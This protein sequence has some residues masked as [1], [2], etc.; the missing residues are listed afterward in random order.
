MYDTKFERKIMGLAAGQA[1]LLTITGRKSDCEFESMRLSHQKIALA[2]Q[3]ADLSN[4]YQN[5]MEQT[6]LVYDY[7]GTGDTTTPLSYSL[8]MTPSALNNYTPITLTDSMGRVVLNSMLA[9]AA[10]AAG[11]PQEGLGTLP[12]ETMRNK[13]IIALGENGTITPAKAEKISSLPYSQQAGFGG[14]ATVSVNTQELSFDQLVKEL[15]NYST[16]PTNSKYANSKYTRSITLYDDNNENYYYNQI[17]TSTG[18][19][20]Q[21]KD[22]YKE[23][24]TASV[25][26]GDILNGNF[27]LVATGVDNWNCALGYSGG[28]IDAIVN[29]D[30]WEQ[31]YN[32]IDELFNTGDSYT[33]MALDYAY[34][35]ISYLISN[36]CENHGEGSGKESEAGEASQYYNDTDLVNFAGKYRTGKNTSDYRVINEAR[37]AVSNNRT[38]GEKYIGLYLRFSKG[39]GRDDDSNVSAVSVN[40]SNVFRAYLTYIVDFMEGVSKTDIK[41]EELYK[42][43]NSVEESKLVDGNTKFTIKIGSEVSSDDMGLAVFYDTLF[44][45]ICSNG[46]VENDKITDNDYLKDML[47]N[48]IYYVS[49]MKDD[50]FY[51]QGNYST[52]IYIKEVED[53]S[54]IAQAEAKYNTEKAKLNA[55]EE[56]LDLKMKNL[57][58]EISALTTEYDT[59]KNTLSKNIDR[60][61]KRY[62]A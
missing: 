27:V 45:Q 12:S 48:G 2:R 34:N 4:E 44:N 7:Y 26:L 28:I 24:R 9:S 39:D 51:Y 46:W 3:L 54:K 18:M 38:D 17:N 13:F 14:G 19:Q 21:E 32:T 23:E 47:Q 16:I 33:Q 8:M 40:L 49:S 25:G 29:S 5:S 56:T 11:I 22:I 6:K 50:N 57:D 53:E 42:V 15:N 20:T 37:N 61:F 10:R 41:G 60:G 35:Q 36:Q 43:G 30:F 59:V 55:K 31:M 52:N 1:R 62:N 58:T